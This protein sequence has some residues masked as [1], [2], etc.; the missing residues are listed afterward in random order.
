MGRVVYVIEDDPF[1]RDWT[2]DFL[3]A[4]L[5]V[6]IK[7]VSTEKEFQDRFEEIAGDQPKCLILD[8]MLQWTEAALDASKP[9]GSFVEA[10]LRCYNKLMKDPRTKNTEVLLHTVLDRGD[11]FGFPRSVGFLRKDEPDAKL[12]TAVRKA[13]SR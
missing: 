5:D 1:W 4:N 2:V 7:P 10:G 8:V 13:L 3:R 12:L 6:V 11:V 9:P